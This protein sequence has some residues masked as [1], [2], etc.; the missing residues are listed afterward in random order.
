MRLHSTRA[1]QRGHGTYG[2]LIWVMTAMPYLIV[3]AV[4]LLAWLLWL[5]WQWGR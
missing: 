5:L 3:L 4:A 2:F 1:H